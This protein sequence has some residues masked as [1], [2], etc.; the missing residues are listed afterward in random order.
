MTAPALKLSDASSARM[1][2]VFSS[3]QGEGPR[4]GERQIFV[5]FGGCNLHCDYCDEPDTIPIPSGK[6][7]SIAKIKSSISSLE[8]RRA[9]KAIS[10]TGGEPLLHPLILSS[11]MRWAHEQGLENYL[12]TNGTLPNALRAVAPSC[13]VVSMDVKLPS[14]TGRA[15]WDLH[16][17]FLKEAPKGTFLKVVLSSKSTEAEWRQ[18]LALWRGAPSRFPLVLQPATPFGGVQPISPA[19]CLAFE[20]MALRYGRQVSVV[21]QWHHLWQ[22]R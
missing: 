3:L 11:L 21:P 19:K 18:V 9:H 17:A 10:W 13:D 4:V 8:K 1:V 22:V 15:T 5:R 12:E 7:W 6:V 20:T 14:S 2:E 16:R